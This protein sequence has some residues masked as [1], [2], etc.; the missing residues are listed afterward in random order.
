MLTLAI[1]E[2]ADRDPHAAEVD[3]TVGAVEAERRAAL[4]AALDD[5]Q[6]AAV[7]GVAAD[8]SELAERA[9]SALLDLATTASA[10]SSPSTDD[11]SGTG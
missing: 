7:A 3:S 2:M 6:R 9:R 1:Y 8:R 5:E 10:R 4:L 11:R